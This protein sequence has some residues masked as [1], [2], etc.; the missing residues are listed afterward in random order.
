MGAALLGWN[1]IAIAIVVDATTISDGSMGKFLH[2]CLL[3]VGCHP[4]FQK[5][6]LLPPSKDSATKTF[7]FS[8]SRPRFF[9]IV[10]PP[11]P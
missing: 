2:R 1:A 10:A 5:R 6:G 8:V 7:V 4:H 9:P 3:D 11:R